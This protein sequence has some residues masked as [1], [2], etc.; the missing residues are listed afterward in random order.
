MEPSMTVAP[1][2]SSQVG[3]AGV[4]A[5]SR[6]QILQP[7]SGSGSPKAGACEHSNGFFVGSHAASF[8]L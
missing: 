3:S 6:V 2:P 7:V 8:S 1:Y 4:T 5:D